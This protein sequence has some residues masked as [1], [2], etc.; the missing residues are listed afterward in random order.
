MPKRLLGAVTVPA[1]HLDFLAEHAAEVDTLTA[2][3]AHG[4]KITALSGSAP[5]ESARILLGEMSRKA[6][7]STVADSGTG[8]GFPKRRG[9]RD[10][11]TT[12]LSRLGIDG[13]SVSAPMRR[14]GLPDHGSQSANTGKDAPLACRTILFGICP[15]TVRKS[16]S[17][18]SDG[19]KGSIRR[20]FDMSE[21]SVEICPGT[22]T[23]FRFGPDPNLSCV[24]AMP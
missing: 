6:L 4:S 7:S 23:T 15:T 21:L 9:I 8:D 12:R 17:R 14:N 19:W 20:V 2:A 24:R 5:E 18:K 22:R 3:A 13:L 10:L 11:E 1:G 16:Q